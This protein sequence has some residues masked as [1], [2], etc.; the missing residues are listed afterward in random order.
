MTPGEIPFSTRAL[1]K[2]DNW[3]ESKHGQC[4]VLYIRDRKVQ[5][6]RVMESAWY[7]TVEEI[8]HLVAG[9]PI[10]LTV[11]GASHPPVSINVSSVRLA[12][13]TDAEE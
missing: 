7:P 10:I 5:G 4:E 11:W 3:D 9:R 13:D 8:A 1:G 12:G 6:S 2:P